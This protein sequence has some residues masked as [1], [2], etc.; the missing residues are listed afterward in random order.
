M[1]SHTI[2]LVE[3]LSK[4]SKEPNF[5]QDATIQAK[6]LSLSKQLTSQLQKPADAALELA[7]WVMTVTMVPKYR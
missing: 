7:F 3:E 1:S 5:E 4:L 2:S 6:A